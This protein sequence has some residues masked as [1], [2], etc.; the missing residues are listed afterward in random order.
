MSL[1]LE[2]S[3]P[4]LR[5]KD[6][7]GSEYPEWDEQKFSA[8]AAKINDSYKPNKTDQIICIEL[9]NIASDSGT[10]TGT[11]TT[12]GRKSTKTKFRAGD[13]LF[14]KLRP[15]LNKYYLTE[16]DGVC[17]TEI[18]VLRPISVTSKLLHLVVQCEQF[19]RVANYQFGSK[20]PRS[21]WKLV[22]ES[23]YHLPT[24]FKEQQKI[25]SFLSSIDTRIEQLEKKK[26]LF[27]QYKKVLM[28]NIFS[29]EIRFKDD[30]GKEYPEWEERTLK[31]VS[32][33]INGVV[34]A[35][36]EATTSPEK[37]RIPVLRAGN[38]GDTLNL[39]KNLIWLNSKSVMH[40]Q[41][42]QLA[43][44]VMCSSSGSKLLVGKNAPLRI[45]WKGTVGAFCSIIRTNSAIC[46]ADYL[47][48]YL[49]S[50]EF[51]KWTQLAYGSNIKNIKT[52]ELENYLV[53]LPSYEEQQKIAS[54]LLSID[55]TIKLISEQIEKTQEFKKGLLQQM[56]V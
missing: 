34:F 32:K 11:S 25:A 23:K 9:E 37:N 31:V 41:L 26:W 47:A 29:Q 38:I 30:Q 20:M 46:D 2:K 45:N 28:Q 24:S 40:K 42:L 39:Q 53:P 13:V 55:R 52:T 36:G 22:S 35:K 10:L 15:Y 48:Y 44:I 43:D 33:I 4:T 14:G 6:D 3:V 5:F 27:E 12:F 19:L 56:F 21:D 51:R 54:F 50:P 1:N 7:Q 49:G 8:I 16:I 18:W 17:T